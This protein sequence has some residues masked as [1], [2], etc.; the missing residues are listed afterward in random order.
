[1]AKKPTHSRGDNTP[2]IGGHSLPSKL[3]APFA[4]DDDLAPNDD[5]GRQAYWL[6]KMN[7]GAVSLKFRKSDFAA[8]DDP[9]KRLLIADIQTALGVA[10]FKSDVL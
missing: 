9:T 6:V 10:P 1:M 4:N 8:M 2:I 5:L 3:I 7:A